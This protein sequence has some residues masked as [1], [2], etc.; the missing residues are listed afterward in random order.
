MTDFRRAILTALLVAVAFTHIASASGQQ[1]S[2][3]DSVT[4]WMQLAELP[5]FT[6]GVWSNDRSGAF[7]LGLSGDAPALVDG[8]SISNSR[9]ESCIPIGVPT[10]MHRPY[11]FEFVYEPGRI[12]MLLEFDGMTR[13]IY[14]DGRSHPDDPD[15]TYAGHSIG[16]WEDDTLVVDTVGF[17][18]EVRVTSEVIAGGP[19][20]VIER[21]SLAGDDVL[22]IETTVAAPYALQEPWTYTREYRRQTDWTVNEY[23]CIQNPRAILDGNSEP[24]PDLTP[25]Q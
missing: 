13:R 11:P 25:P 14:T 2:D 21:M 1:T 20:Q 9:V 3:A 19:M 23:Y 8:A 6:T 7:P 10:V 4:E 12:L 18:P 17:L 22:T 16:H 15:L 24:L 5:D